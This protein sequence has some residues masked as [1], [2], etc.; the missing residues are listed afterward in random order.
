MNIA[1]LAVTGEAVR[2][3]SS[4]FSPSFES[5]PLFLI[6]VS[7][8]VHALQGDDEIVVL[9]TNPSMF[10]S[11]Y[12]G[13]GS[14]TFVITPR[15][16]SPV[17]SKNLRGHRGIIEHTLVSSDDIGY[18]GLVIAGIEANVMDNDG[19]FGWVYTVDQ[20]GFHLMT[21]DGEGAFS[22]YLYPTTVPQDDLYVNIV[23][24]A[25]RDENRY[26]F[27][28][29]AIAEILYWSSGEMEPKEVRVTYNTNVMKLDNTEINLMLK[30]FVDVDGGK[31]KD[32]RYV[33]TEQSV[34]PVDITLLPSVN[35]IAGAKSVFIWQG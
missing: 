30:L 28:N 12:G 13:L 3:T 15:T 16:V 1:N 10:L 26:V 32:Y 21:E 34:L 18:D 6:L 7:F 23:A 24:P 33:N 19:S 22:F 27:V 14:D 5:D 20:G 31:T 11:I 8:I 4:H 17:V 25:A 9:S 35:N 2:K 29:D